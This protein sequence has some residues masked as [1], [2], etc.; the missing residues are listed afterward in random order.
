MIGNAIKGKG[1]RG[2]LEYLLNGER[3]TIIGGTLAGN[4]PREMA[5]EIGAVRRLRPKLGKAI[6]HLPLSAHPQDRDLSDQEWSDIC[7]YV[8]QGLGYEG[9]PMKFIRHH[10]TEHDHV[11][12]VIC[13]INA[14]GQTVS[15]S[16]EYRRIEALLR[17]VERQYRLHRVEQPGAGSKRKQ[18]KQE[19]DMNT[20]KE[21]HAPALTSQPPE[22]INGI[23]IETGP[24]AEGIDLPV[25]AMVM[26]QPQPPTLSKRAADKHK[27]DQ[28]RE[29]LT[30]QYTQAM[31]EAFG[32]QLRHVHAHKGGAVLYFDKPKALRDDG[33][34]V[35]AHNMGHEEAAQLIVRAALAKQWKSVTFTG[36]PAFVRAA[37]LKAIQAGLTVVPADTM[38][39]GVL[40]E[41]KAQLCVQAVKLAGQPIQLSK[42]AAFRERRK[43]QGALDPNYTPRINTTPVRRFG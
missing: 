24:G 41:V 43:E 14:Q 1:A 31:R 17:D 22:P 9:C 11:H 10:D 34:N 16:N 23:D 7:R 37:M 13:R 32:E 12:I 8:A 15:D 21:T 3:A 27:R 20:Q 18:Q 38:Q 35:T 29:L 30:P 40:D 28:K 6:L 5:A 26:S 39:A 42:L 33:T 4:T 25:V 36:P 19:S 2:L